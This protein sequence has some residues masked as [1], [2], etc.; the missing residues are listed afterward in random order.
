MGNDGGDGILPVQT[1]PSWTPEAHPS[2]RGTSLI[3]NTLTP[4][5]H[6]RAL[7]I[8]GYLVYKETYTKETERI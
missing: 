4:Y 1:G 2:Y 3:R 7:G 8:Q 6:H 5:N